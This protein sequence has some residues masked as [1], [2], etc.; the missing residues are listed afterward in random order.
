MSYDINTKGEDRKRVTPFY[1][2][3]EEDKE[4]L[5]SFLFGS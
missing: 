1:C 5:L 2:L 4:P 3:K